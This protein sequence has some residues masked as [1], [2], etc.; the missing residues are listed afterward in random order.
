MNQED[1]LD[2]AQVDFLSYNL[3]LKCLFNITS[4]CL[5]VIIMTI[6]LFCRVL[7]SFAA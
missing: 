2:R 6:K 7:Y 1:H 3:T 5:R 4:E